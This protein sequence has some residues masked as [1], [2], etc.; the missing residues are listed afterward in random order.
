MSGSLAKGGVD[1]RH[2]DDAFVH[3]SRAFWTERVTPCFLCNTETQQRYTKHRKADPRARFCCGAFRLSSHELNKED[4]LV[5]K[6]GP[7][8]VSKGAKILSANEKNILLGV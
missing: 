4:E 5:V 3:L 8:G 2:A 7:G 1:A 6:G